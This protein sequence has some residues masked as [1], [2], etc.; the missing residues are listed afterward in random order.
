MEP[1]L[2]IVGIV[3]GWLF[4]LLL[5]WWLLRRN[6]V[7][8]R[9]R[10]RLGFDEAPAGQAAPLSLEEL[11]PLARWLYV[12][13]F[14]GSTAPRAFLALTALG[15]AAGVVAALAIVR[16]GAVEQTV[17]LARVVPSGV[18]DLMLP[19]VYLAPWTAVA[20]LAGIPAL[21]VRAA[22]RRR[23][24]Q[25]EQDLPITLELLATLAEAGLGFDAALDRILRTQPADRP[26]AR[27]LRTFQL[28]VMAGRPRVQSFRRLA[29][30]LDVPALAVFVSA[31][32]QAEQV[33]AGVADVLRRQA[34]DLRSRRREDSLAVA[35][36]LPVKLLFPLVLCFLPGILVVTLGPILLEFFKLTEALF[37][38]RGLL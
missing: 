9:Q 38:S 22:A 1:A 33:G 2:K 36:A 28:E 5:L 31:M 4:A 10:R 30:R 17:A 35:A 20:I 8:R 3:I 34:D 12:A 26:L 37:R 11:G 24:I 6:W 14:R 7:G 29:R 15:L 19:L 25:A 21:V 32:V 18:G 13:G 27:E 23:R 16:S